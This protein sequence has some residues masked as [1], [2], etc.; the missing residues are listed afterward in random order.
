MK[1]II[2]AKVRMANSSL[3]NLFINTLRLG[4]GDVSAD[5]KYLRVQGI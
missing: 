5:R 2:I 3:L 1:I 4:S